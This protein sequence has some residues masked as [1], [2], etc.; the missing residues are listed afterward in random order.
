MQSRV[1]EF[2]DK[3]D[4]TVEVFVDNRESE[5]IISEL[6]RLGAEVTVRQ[7]DLGDY[8]LSDRMV[9]ERKTSSDFEASV[10]DGRLF[11]QAGRMEE[12]C[13]FPIMIIEGPLRASRIN[14][15]AFMGAYMAVLVDFGISIINTREERETAEMVFLLAK[16]EQLKDKRPIRL[17]AKRKA[18][19]LEHQQLRVLEAF[20]TIG[21]I[22]AKKLLDEFSGLEKVFHADIKDLEAVLGKAKA[23]K[24][25]DLLHAKS[26]GE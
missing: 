2:S 6:I 11:E 23:G 17:L 13:E 25:R 10:I 1:A 3:K 15:N 20:P 21:P 8:R 7:L 19:T 24:L 9:I 26:G 5:A 14:Q 18:Y 16:R 12:G 4:D 22:M